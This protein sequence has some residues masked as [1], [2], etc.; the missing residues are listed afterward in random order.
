MHMPCREIRLTRVCLKIKFPPSCRKKSLFLLSCTT[1]RDSLS[2]ME[3]I[4]EHNTELVKINLV[5]WA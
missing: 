5:N 1:D 4:R 2:Y 3:I